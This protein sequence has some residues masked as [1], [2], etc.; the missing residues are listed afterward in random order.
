MT[1]PSDLPRTLT[2]EKSI[3][4]ASELI[5]EIDALL[6]FEPFQNFVKRNADRCDKM[7][8]SVLHGEMDEVSRNNLRHQLIG[9]IGVMKAM[10]DDRKG[11]VS[12]LA[13]FGIKSGD[14]T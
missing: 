2:Q 13:G 12:V 3:S 7:A 5:M 6:E 1:N 11:Q 8:A 14:M 9:S 4:T 10:M